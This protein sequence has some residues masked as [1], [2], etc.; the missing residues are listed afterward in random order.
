MSRNKSP[1]EHERRHFLKTVGLAGVS[2]GLLRA[3]PLVAGMMWGRSAAAQNLAGVNKVI[4]VYVPGG[5]PFENGK[6]LYTPS[7]SLVLPPA[8]A[9]LEA[10]KNEC[11][12]FSDAAVT[13]G[14][15]HGRTMKVLGAG[16]NG[17]GQITTVDV[18]LSETLGANSPYPHLLLGS[19]SNVG[20][21]AFASQKNRQ[22]VAYQDNPVAAYERLFGI[23]GASTGGGSGGGSNAGGSA[24]EKMMR[25]K[26]VLELQKEEIKQLRSKLG[27]EEKDRL[28]QHLS[29]IEKI[30][31]RL[32]VSPP[33][34]GGNG[35]GNS[36]SFN[37][38]GFVYNQSDRANFTAVC[39][40]QVDL[41]VLALQSNQT[42]VVS[43]MFG[44]DQ[45][46]HS[47]PELN[48][49]GAYHSSIH[50]GANKPPTDHIE[51][52]SHLTKRVARL[53]QSLKNAKDDM[54]NSL[55]D[56]TIILQVADMADG[57]LHSTN[58]APMMLAGGGSAVKRGQVT[59]CGEHYD[60][61]DTV[62]ELVGMTG[63][64]VPRYGAGAVTGVIA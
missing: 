37:S 21:H 9:P 59:T 55:L 34:T 44:N 22:P 38:G 63:R 27:R 41:A 26:S 48:F 33:S 62:T 2:S 58:N 3:S 12:F 29:A 49:K 11:V 17:Q 45:S 43:M 20:N 15:G 36:G 19:H 6:S 64:G 8:S 40:L 50:V 32:N 16:K 24:S 18:F 47:M 51:T 25:A 42:R 31:S 56:S 61:L 5:S 57:R 39:D 14:G 35:G 7:Q 52:R 4:F 46:E 1:L 30:E 60:L 23:G 53:I 28:D 13:G 54:G 10:V